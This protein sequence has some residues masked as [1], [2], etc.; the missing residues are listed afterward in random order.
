MRVPAEIE[1]DEVS[2]AY[3]PTPVYACERPIS[4]ARD[5]CIETNGNTKASNKNDNAFLIDTVM[6]NYFKLKH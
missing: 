1:I 4:A 5:S 3:V 2:S 6:N